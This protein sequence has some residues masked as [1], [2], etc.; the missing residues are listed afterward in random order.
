MPKAGQ[1][2][3][4]KTTKVSVPKFLSQGSKS[5][6]HPCLLALAGVENKVNMVDLG[7]TNG[8]RRR[9]PAPRGLTAAALAPAKA[10]MRPPSCLR[11]LAD[12]L[13]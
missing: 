13:L 2:F 8:A 10:R 11:R 4:K 7:M 12:R 3:A 9:G 6:A 1:L 5:V